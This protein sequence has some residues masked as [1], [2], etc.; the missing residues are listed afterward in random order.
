MNPNQTPSGYSLL[1]LLK[2]P[3]LEGQPTDLTIVTGEHEFPVHRRELVKSP[4]YFGVIIGSGLKE[5]SD[6]KITIIDIDCCAG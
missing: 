3:G 6:E 2:K 4:D 5:A 1:S